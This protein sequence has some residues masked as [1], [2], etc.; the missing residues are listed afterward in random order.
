MYEN[1]GYGIWWCGD[2]GY[3][4]GRWGVGCGGDK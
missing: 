2:I 1:G 4:G 3:E